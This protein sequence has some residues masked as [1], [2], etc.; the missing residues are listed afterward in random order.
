VAAVRHRRLDANPR[1]AGVGE[2]RQQGD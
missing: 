2:D 1:L